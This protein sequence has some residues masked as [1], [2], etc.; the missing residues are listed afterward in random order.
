MLGV[1]HFESKS[2]SK[3]IKLNFFWRFAFYKLDE[4]ALFHYKISG[5]HREPENLSRQKN[6]AQTRW[7]ILEN[8]KYFFADFLNQPLIFAVLI[9]LPIFENFWRLF[10]SIILDTV[11]EYLPPNFAH[12][13]CPWVKYLFQIILCYVTNVMKYF[14][15]I[16]MNYVFDICYCFTLHSCIHIII[17]YCCICW[18]CVVN[19]LQQVVIKIL[20]FLYWFESFRGVS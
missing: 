14:R 8:K 12:T 13:S 11:V 3:P 1:Q 7:G 2:P 5:N 4:V 6:R 15:A 16:T 9:S 19:G 17:S 10:N 20:L 18:W